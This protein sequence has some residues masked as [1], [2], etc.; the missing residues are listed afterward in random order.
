MMTWPNFPS[1][2]ELSAY[3]FELDQIIEVD[4]LIFFIPAVRD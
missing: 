3:L 4:F 1:S 2:I